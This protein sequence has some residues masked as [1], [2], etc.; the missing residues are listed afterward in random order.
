MEVEFTR[1]GKL[2]YIGTTFAGYVG[3]LT[4]MRPGVFSISVDER[5]KGGQLENLIEALLVKGT[6]VGS[7]LIRR[8]LDTVE[9]FEEAVNIM[10]RCV[11][12]V[13]FCLFIICLGR[14]IVAFS[15]VS[16][17]LSFGLSTDCAAAGIHTTRRYSVLHHGRRQ[18]R[19]RCN[20]HSRSQRPCR[21]LA[22][23]S[24]FGR[25]HGDEPRGRPRHYARRRRASLSTR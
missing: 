8:T 11:S 14:S 13:G 24:V 12:A 10:V 22:I 25:S 16:P 17:L 4:G 21:H 9:D 6:S 19:R 5:D 20:H 15:K 1:G 7:L 2:H 18:T 3:L 23:E